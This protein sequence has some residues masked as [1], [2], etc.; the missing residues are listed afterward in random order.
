M[1]ILGQ[2]NDYIAIYESGLVVFPPTV[3]TRPDSEDLSGT[4]FTFYMDEFGD[5][6]V[7]N[8]DEYSGASVKSAPMH[9]V[10]ELI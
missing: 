5:L 1:T 2:Y 10:W 9:S 4:T 7:A 6:N 3:S 8:K